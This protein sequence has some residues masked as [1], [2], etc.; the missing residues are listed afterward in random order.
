[1][2]DQEKW[3]LSPEEIE[4]RIRKQT[5]KRKKKGKGR[6]QNQRLKLLYL[7][8]YLLEKTDET[9]TKKVSEI[10]EHF[11]NYYKIPV[12]QKTVCSDLRI[13]GEYGYET[14]YDGRT[15]GWRIV[16]REFDTQELQLL[17]DSVQS[18]RFITQKQAKTLTDKLKAKASR[19]DRVLLDRRCYVPN[20]V[21]SMNDSIF[22]HLDD[23]HTAIANDWQ[24]TFKYFYFTPKKQKA[25]YKKGELYAA[26]PYALLWSDNNYY[27][28]A[29]ESGKMK[30][31]RVDKM[32]G[33]SIVAQKREGKKEF[34]ELNLSERSLRMFSMFSGKVQKVKIRF[35]NHLAN[36]VIDR[37]G[38]DIVMY[39]DDEKH[40]TIHTDI[41]VSPQFFGWVC[42]L[43]KAARIVAPAEVVEEM[44]NYVK[45]IA[46]MY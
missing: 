24:I 33:I 26:S 30:H 17:I 23:L 45:G 39:P 15:R 46:E 22:Y 40:F 38:Q 20:R 12:E 32:D 3:E 1:M 28:L 35:S 31:F 29:F 8:D 27:L 9:H 41:E 37:F 7:L 10:I 25:F 16:D 6:S 18:S 14:Q 5:E 13:L 21:R 4:E 2:A 42:G 34:K 44:G 19:Y 11:E 36:V 43:G